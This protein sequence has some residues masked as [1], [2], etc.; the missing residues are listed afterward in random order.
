MNNLKI[1]IGLMGLAAKPIPPPRGNVCAPNEIVY[2]I[3]L[4]LKKAGQEVIVFTGLDSSSA[5]T[6][7][8][9]GLKSTWNQFGTDL[10]LDQETYAAKRIEYEKILSKEAVEYFKNNRVDF[11]HSHD[12]RTNPPIFAAANVPTL[13]TVH[14]DLASNPIANDPNWVNILKSKNFGFANISRDNKKFCQKIGLNN[15][16]YTPNGIDTEKFN[17]FGGERKGILVV[18]RMIAPKKIKEAIEIATDLN[19][20]IVLIGPAGPTKEDGEYFADLKIN[21]FNK[22]NIDY[23]GYLDQDKII[24]YYQKAR[25]LLFISESEGM[26]LSVLEAQSTG[27][28]IVANRVGGVKDIIIEGKTGCFIDD[29]NNRKEIEERMIQA[30]KINPTD[31]RKNIVM[32]YSYKKM[33]DNY[34]KAYKKY[35]GR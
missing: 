24:S 13:Y 19:E 22:P 6:K 31:C 11:I 1:K 29:I 26:P 34:L 30:K 2:Q 23:V 3:A 8:S 20:R 35:L 32:N 15:V 17:F 33:V 9:A 28:P 14:G 21:Y 4:G 5:L 25:V 16:A 10:E 27:L 12:I 7:V 18:A